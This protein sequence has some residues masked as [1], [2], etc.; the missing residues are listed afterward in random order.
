[1]P[2]LMKGLLYVVVVNGQVGL[3]V[4]LVRLGQLL[5]QHDILSLQDVSL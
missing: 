3:R 4:D 5:W 2:W 1:M